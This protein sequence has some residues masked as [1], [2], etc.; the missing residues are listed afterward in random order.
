MAALLADHYDDSEL[1]AGVIPNP[2]AQ[3]LV[4]SR[5]TRS[6]STSS[7]LAATF[8][9][10]QKR[11]CQ[12]TGA[13]VIEQGDQVFQLP[14]LL[15]EA[16][17]RGAVLEVD[18]RVTLGLATT[19]GAALPSIDVYVR[20]LRCASRLHAAIDAGL[21]LVERCTGR[22]VDCKKEEVFVIT[23]CATGQRG[24]GRHVRRP[25]RKPNPSV[26]TLL[27]PSRGRRQQSNAAKVSSSYGR[28]WS[29]S[30]VRSDLLA[31]D[32]ALRRTHVRPD[33]RPDGRAHAVPLVSAHERT[34]LQTDRRAVVRLPR[35]DDASP[36]KVAATP[37]L[38]RG[39]SAE[40][41]GATRPDRNIARRPTRPRKIFE[42]PRGGAAA[43]LSKRRA[44]Q[45]RPDVRAEP[46]ADGRTDVRAVGRADVRPP[47]GYPVRLS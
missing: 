25:E 38:R 41:G 24:L 5:R 4:G 29:P 1:E 13:V 17:C 40:R 42:A 7:F 26:L 35:G 43:P 21:H 10:A 32:G 15:D 19:R 2:L 20:D 6:P 23:Y 28:D 3:P 45:V 12:E 30:Q 39:D 34:E 36:E 27:C 16:A 31:L 9:S 37:R 47:S 8:S 22:L 18:G 33:A 14:P 44:T 11:V 46:A